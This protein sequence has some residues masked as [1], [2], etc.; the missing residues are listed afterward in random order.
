[1]RVLLVEDSPKLLLSVTEG[2]ERSG[3]AVDCV[4]DGKSGLLYA[5]TSEYDAVVLDIMLPQMDGLSVLRAMRGKGLATPVLLLTARDA[6]EDRV[7]GL[8]RGADDYLVKPFHL[9]ELVARLQ[10]LIRRSKGAT[11]SVTTVGELEVDLGARQ[12]RFRGETIMLT[13]REFAVLE[14]LCHRPGRPASRAELEEHLYDEHSQVNSNAV[15]VAVYQLRS[16]L[17]AAG[18]PEVIGTRRGVGYYFSAEGAE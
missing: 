9:S 4:A 16:K 5:Q 18:C 12:L 13:A 3:F 8:Q 10:A 14:Y 1:M 7:S 11:T 15:D 17:K 2:L 6:V